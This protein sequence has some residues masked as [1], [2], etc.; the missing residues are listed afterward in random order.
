MKNIA[1]GVTY[2]PSMVSTFRNGSK[3]M[4]EYLSPGSYAK[5][6]RE[7]NAVSLAG[8]RIKQNTLEIKP[9]T[10][11]LDDLKAGAIGSAMKKTIPAHHRRIE[12]SDHGAIGCP[13]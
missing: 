4:K 1:E 9:L 5:F 2:V 6:A 10:Q 11:A 13:G 7:A 8:G 12:P 3:L